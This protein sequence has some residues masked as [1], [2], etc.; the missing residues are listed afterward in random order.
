M[1]TT[2]TTI[3]GIKFSISYPEDA[4][5][6]T[7]AVNQL[8]NLVKERGS[9]KE[10]EYCFGTKLVIIKFPNYTKITSSIK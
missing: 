9:A 4:V 8:K 7:T 6:R 10:V 2:T 3:E 1:A 5:S